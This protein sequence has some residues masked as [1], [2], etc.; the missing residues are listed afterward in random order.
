MKRIFLTIVLATS[1]LAHAME[2]KGRISIRHD[3]KENV[4]IACHTENRDGMTIVTE[5]I[6][7]LKTGELFSTVISPKVNPDYQDC[8]IADRVEALLKQKIA[9]YERTMPAQE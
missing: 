8:L 7:N 6:K 3:S 4:I 2:N 9:D 1:F 5:V